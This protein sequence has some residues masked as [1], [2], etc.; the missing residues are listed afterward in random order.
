MGL[1][2]QSPIM[3]NLVLFALLALAFGEPEAAPEADA[4]LVHYGLFYSPYYYG[5]AG[6]YGHYLGKREAAPEADASH[7]FGGYY[8]PYYHGHAGYYGHYLGKREAEAAPEADASH[9]FG[10]FYGYSPRYHYGHYVV[11]K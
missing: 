1:L 8:D 3:K 10:G 6:Y 5:H 7:Y 11:G 9:Y 2:L 4:S